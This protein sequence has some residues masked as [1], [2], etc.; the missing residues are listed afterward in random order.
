MFC[1][2]GARK[3]Y[4]VYVTHSINVAI[5]L[6]KMETNEETIIAGILHD[7]FEEKTLVTL[8]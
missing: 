4:E 6:A 7:I 8:K 3:L 5:I 2:L 1:L